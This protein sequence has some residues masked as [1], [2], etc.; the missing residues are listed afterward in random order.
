MISAFRHKSAAKVL[1]FFYIHKR[2][3]VFFEKKKYF[4]LF[5]WLNSGISDVFFDLKTSKKYIYT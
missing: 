3:R 2:T 4:S 5:L 1:L